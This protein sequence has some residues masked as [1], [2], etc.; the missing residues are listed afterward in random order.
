MLTATCPSCREWADDAAPRRA[1][2]VTVFTWGGVTHAV[3]S[4]WLA[5]ALLGDKTPIAEALGRWV[6]HCDVVAQQGKAA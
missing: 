3:P 6:W 2:K 4:M 1:G 5:A